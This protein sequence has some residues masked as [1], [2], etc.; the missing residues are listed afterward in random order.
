MSSPKKRK[1]DSH[2]K[3]KFFGKNQNKKTFMEAGQSGFLV[4]CNFREKDCVRESYSVL[5][6]FA[7][8]LYGKQEC[9]DSKEIPENNHEDAASDEEEIDISKQ[10]QLD[11]VK[12]QKDFKQKSF[13]FQL[14]DNG[15]ISNCLF[16]KATVPDVLELG[17]KIYTEIFE[18]KK[19][20]TKNVLRFIPV[21]IVCKASVPDIINAAGKLF[22]KHLLKEPKTF[23]IMFNRRL[24]NKVSRDDVIKELADLAASKNINNKVDLKSP[25]IAIIVEV[26]KGLCCLSC[27]PD[28]H[29][30]RKYNL[31]E[32]VA[33]SN[34]KTEEVPKETPEKTDI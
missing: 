30:F 27:L 33:S 31:V 15:N 1:M 28:F 18:T 24:N 32:L 11:I 13:R 29:K 3:R 6:E 10:L 25:Q 9:S 23:A 21:E 4:T 8:M 19:S 26:M 16:I 7:D 12:V 34:N 5:N 14:T 20:R 17:N 22:D 2:Q